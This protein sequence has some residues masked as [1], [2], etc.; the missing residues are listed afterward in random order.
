MP[1]SRKRP[2]EVNDLLPK[3]G[4]D[5]LDNMMELKEWNRNKRNKTTA[6]EKQWQHQVRRAPTQIQEQRVSE[7]T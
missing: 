3:T 6:T 5:I 2:I 4:T 1:N 7:I